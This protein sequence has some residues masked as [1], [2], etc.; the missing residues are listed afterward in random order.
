M[1]TIA[2]M[3]TQILYS[4]ESHLSLIQ[5]N[6]LATLKERDA[7]IFSSNTFLIQKNKQKFLKQ[8][9]HHSLKV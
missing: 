8:F 3:V 4:M 5:E 1:F 9:S 6:L 2:F 7:E